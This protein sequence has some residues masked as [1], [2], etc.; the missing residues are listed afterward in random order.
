M[1]HLFKEDKILHFKRIEEIL[2]LNPVRS[3]IKEKKEAINLFSNKY[4]YEI[5]R[6]VPFNWK[7]ELTY[8]ILNIRS[9]TG[10]LFLLGYRKI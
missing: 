1:S 8:Y 4:I 5:L 2:N 3:L 7:S 6:L 9:N 10:K